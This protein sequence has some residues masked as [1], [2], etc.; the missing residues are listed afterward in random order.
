MATSGWDELAAAL[1]GIER[2]GATHDLPVVERVRGAR[3][4][5]GG[6][7]LVTFCS[8]D[9]LALGQDPRVR[10][11]AAAAIRSYGWST[12]A[13][14][15]LTG[16][17]PWHR[18]LEAALA[19]FLKCEDAAIFTGGYAANLG[20]LPT[21]A[22]K[23]TFI[24]LDEAC[25]PSQFDACK[26]SGAAWSAYPHG[27]TA[28]LAR[29][30]ARA[31]ARD[32]YAVTDGVFA[33]G[34]DLGPLPEVVRIARRYGAR[35][36]LDDAH[37]FGVFGRH[38]RGVAEHFGLE[39]E[40]D[41]RVGTLSKAGG[42]VGGFVAGPRALIEYLR[43]RAR[44]YLYTSALPAAVRAAGLRALEAIAAEPERRRRLWAMTRAV[45]TR[46]R[47]MGFDLGACASPL[48]VV[49][50]GSGARTRAAGRVLERHG[51]HALVMAPPHVPE[52]TGRI[53]CALTL[54]HRPA[55]LERLFGALAEV[56]A[57]PAAD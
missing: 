15:G 31:R 20:L 29:L 44:I 11:A 41:L 6:R 47:H 16:N 3:V 53:R 34:G 46:V 39:A 28:A 40:V 13:A 57:G 17:S 30:L 45:H 56:A 38:G 24:A 27:D 51:V 48:V 10:R 32:R 37:G 7:E 8:N 18:D 19:R 49:R 35:V 1:E 42:G 26:L 54:H 14:R 5:I 25:H 12:A 33:G 4:R 36:L 22:G 9:Y 52:G 21:L 2:T 43:Q 50:L 23:D 55:D